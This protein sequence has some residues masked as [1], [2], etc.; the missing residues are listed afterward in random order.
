[1]GLT[2]SVRK[3]MSMEAEGSA[4]ERFLENPS[5]KEYYIAP[6]LDNSCPILEQ[7]PTVMETICS[8]LS[9]KDL[10]RL[11]QTCQLF[12]S[13][14]GEFLRHECCSS[15]LSA[16]LVSFRT[17][18]TGLLSQF[19]QQLMNSLDS[20]LAADG[21]ITRQAM[22]KLL[23]NMEHYNKQ[24]DRVSVVQET[25]G[26]PHRGNR[27]YVAVERDDKLGREVVRVREVCWLQVGYTWEGIRPGVFQVAVRIKIGDNFRW[28]HRAQEMTH[29]TVRWP[30]EGVGGEKVVMVNKEWWTMI[31]NKQT[32]GREVGQGLRVEWEEVKGEHT[33]WVRVILPVV[34][35][36]TEGSISFELKDVECPWWKA[37]LLFDFIELK[38]LR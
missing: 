18:N 32:P 21:D 24:V 4:R 22:Y 15:K 2:Q 9:L 33:G 27:T 34:L 7:P 19:E 12:S 37:D 13:L 23:A 30:G 11:S 1:M 26:F 10:S 20:Q 17:R 36:E 35:V 8:F 38:K 3:S 16:S 14:V 25:V 31:K 28:P 29:W 5:M 6:L